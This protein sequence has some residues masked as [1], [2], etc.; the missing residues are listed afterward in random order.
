MAYFW[1]LVSIHTL[2]NQQTNY[3]NNMNY[4][5]PYPN[6]LSINPLGG[7]LFPLIPAQDNIFATLLQ[8]NNVAMNGQS[9]F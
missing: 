4:N 3:N 9:S 1:F 2:F 7:L 8:I 6:T 5:Q